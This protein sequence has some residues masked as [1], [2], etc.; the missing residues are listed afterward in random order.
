[1]KRLLLA[2]PA[3]GG[4]RRRRERR[5]RDAAAADAEHA[6]AE[7][8]ADRLEVDH[9]SN[10]SMMIAHASNLLRDQIQDVDELATKALG[11]LAVDGSVFALLVA[12]RGD[13]SRLWWIPAVVFVVAGVLLVFTAFPH[14]KLDAGPPP[15]SWYANYGTEPQLMAKRQLLA[16]FVTAYERNDPVLARRNT[17]FR[18]G[19]AVFI[20]GVVGFAI[21]AIVR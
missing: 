5:R 12:V 14:S 8:E 2:L 19:F 18:A 7:A 4:L 17:I 9:L 21:L 1:V 6:E 16:D 10:L 20:A 13:V 15:A 3:T 11:V